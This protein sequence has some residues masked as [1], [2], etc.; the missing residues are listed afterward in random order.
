MMR[1][2][3]HGRA[4]AEGDG[5][6]YDPIHYATLRA[7]EDRH[8]WF[9]ARKRA[10]GAA[11]EPYAA[12]LRGGHVLEVGCG[13]GVMLDFLRRTCDGCTVVG[14]DLFREGLRYARDRG[15][16]ALVQGDVFA[17][18]FR[19][20]FAMVGLFDVLEH[21]ADHSA[22][23]AAI[24]GTIRCDGLLAI[25]VPACQS[26]WSEYDVASRHVRRYD[27]A[28]LRHLLGAA[29]FNVEYLTYFLAAAVP[30]LWARRRLL[31]RAATTQAGAHPEQ[32]AS[33]ELRV[34]PVL[35][36]A[37]GCAFRWEP[38]AIRRRKRLPCGTSLL[39]IARAR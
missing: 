39:A 37:L 22:V 27:A 5:A 13:T 1:Q 36:A 38:W 26:L 16:S 35:N 9:A 17:S 10:V 12:A 33:D 6:S 15:H 31:G 28:M 24:R 20:P 30:L 34:T 8:F 25:T 3:N 23:L 18:P 11:L 19:V 21:L 32:I 7:V 29:G 14:L 4:R 2:A